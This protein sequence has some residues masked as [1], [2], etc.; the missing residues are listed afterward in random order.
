MRGITAGLI[1]GLVGT[2]RSC[3]QSN[4]IARVAP[5]APEPTITYSYFWPFIVITPL[6]GWSNLQANA[7]ALAAR[8]D[9][10][11]QSADQ[12]CC[13]S[14]HERCYSNDLLCVNFYEA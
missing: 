5:P 6:A 1:G 12:S 7:I 13:Y 8:P 9:R 14:S 2:I 4:G 3:G 11:Y 10:A